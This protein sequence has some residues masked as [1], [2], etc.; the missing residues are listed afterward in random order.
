MRPDGG[1]GLPDLRHRHRD[2]DEVS[3]ARQLLQ[4]AGAQR[5]RDVGPGI[6]GADSVSGL[7]EQ[8][9][10]GGAEAPVSEEGEGAHEDRAEHLAHLARLGNRHREEQALWTPWTTD[11]R[12]RRPM[13]KRPGRAYAPRPSMAAVK[14]NGKATKAALHLHLHLHLQLGDLAR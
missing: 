8:G 10:Q 14:K 12:S 3:A 7:A 6:E 5:G 13:V 11:G 4:R 9:A 1:E 2:D